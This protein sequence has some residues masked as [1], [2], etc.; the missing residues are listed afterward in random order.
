MKISFW[1]MPSEIYYFSFGMTVSSVSTCKLTV[2]FVSEHSRHRLVCKERGV[3][4][5]NTAIVVVSAC[6]VVKG[7]IYFTSVSQQQNAL[8]EYQCNGLILR[9]FQTAFP[10]NQD[11]IILRLREKQFSLSLLQYAGSLAGSPGAH[12]QCLSKLLLLHRKKIQAFIKCT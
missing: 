8:T 4:L 5:A 9:H 10:W 6:S 2:C 12:F 11:F 7:F 3:D 1:R